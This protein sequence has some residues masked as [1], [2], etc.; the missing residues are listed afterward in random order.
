MQARRSAVVAEVHP[1]AVGAHRGSQSLDADLDGQLA[2]LAGH[3]SE[4][5]SVLESSWPTSYH[6]PIAAAPAWA[7]LSRMDTRGGAAAPSATGRRAGA[8]TRARPE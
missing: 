5:E 6:S 8:T 3:R 1:A 7:V 4:R 2:A